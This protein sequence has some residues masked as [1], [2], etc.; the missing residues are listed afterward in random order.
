MKTRV[1]NIVDG[2]GSMRHL[3]TTVT[4]MYKESMSKLKQA[5]VKTIIFGSRAEKV[6]DFDV[7]Y[8]AFVA[9]M[10]W[11]RLYDTIVEEVHKACKKKRGRIVVNV[12]TDG[13]DNRSRIN[14]VQMDRLLKRLAKEY[15]KDIRLIYSSIGEAAND[16]GL[17]L[18]GLGWNTASAKG[19]TPDDFKISYGATTK[20]VNDAIQSK[21]TLPTRDSK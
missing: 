5:K 19:V 13:K 20:M 1:L 15:N 21:N 16:V 18:R 12:F 7:Q 10:Q 11:T 2:S 6:T 14:E 4:E 8:P 17:V 9:Q 3:V